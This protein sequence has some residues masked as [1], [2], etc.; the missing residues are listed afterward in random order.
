[1]SVD[2]ALVAAARRALESLYGLALG[3]LTDDQ[4]ASA[5]AAAAAQGTPVAPNEPRFLERVVDHLPIDES[6]LFRDDDLWAWL[7]A[8]AG[9]ALLERVVMRGRALRVLSLGC[10]TGQEAFSLAITFQALLEGMG[11]PGSAASNY[12]E[13]HGIDSS[14]ERV[15][16]AR[17]GTVNS[18]SVQRC[19]SDRLR[20]RVSKL[21]P[22]S[23]RQRIDP[24]VRAMCR[25][26]VGNL[27][28]LA[29]KGNVALTGWD[30]VLCRH[31]LIYF[32]PE[33]AERLAAMLARALDPDTFLVLAAAEA[34]LAAGTGVLAPLAYLGAG[35]IRT[36]A[37]LRA[38]GEKLETRRR[39]RPAFRPSLAGTRASARPQAASISKSSA[40]SEERDA[41]RASDLVRSAIEHAVAGRSGEAVREARAACF[42]DPRHLLSRMVL[43][44]ALIETDKERGLEVLR[45]LL[46]QVSVMPQEAEVPSA[47]GLSVGQLTSAVRLLLR[48]REGM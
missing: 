41:E 2:P 17:G 20:G 40:R 3:G 27:V 32:R 35:R 18:W 13:I 8:D 37:E 23:G 14:P 42:L 26:E 1:M 38:E 33:E 21:D 16:V 11:I 4:I 12:V 31:V 28:E 39:P 24:T 22:V 9:P 30:L 48:E 10:S 7:E 34:H 46:V 45:E 25:F 29:E 19:R 15:E 6:W 5:V 44:K 43:G 47:P 36:L